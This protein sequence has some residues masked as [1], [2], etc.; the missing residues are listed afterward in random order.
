MSARDDK[1]TKTVWHKYAKEYDPIK[2]G[3]IDGKH[4]LPRIYL[5]PKHSN[6]IPCFPGTDTEPHDRA[7]VRAL[8]SRYK[9]NHK[10][11]GDAKRTIFVGRLHPKTDEV[12]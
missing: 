2:V 7:I 5:N 10:V 6:Q 4:S 1:S 11:V 12:F 8:R 3:S 9:P